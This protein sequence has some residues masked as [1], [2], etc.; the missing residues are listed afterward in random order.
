MTQAPRLHFADRRRAYA[1]TIADYLR[2]C[3][4]LCLLT[5]MPGNAG[6]QLIWAGT[7]RLL[8]TH[9]IEVVHY[10]VEAVATTGRAIDRTLLVPGS[11]AWVALWHEWLPALVSAASTRFG[12]VVVLP[13]QFDPR[14]PVV[15][16]ALRQPNVVVF[17]REVPSYRA[18]KVFGRAV[19]AMD[20]ALYAWD[21]E[22]APPGGPTARALAGPRLV[23]L[24]TDAGSLLAGWGLRPNPALADDISA[25]TTDLSEFLGA[26]SASA[27]V[28]TDRLH[29]AVAAI[30][31]GR[32]VDYVDPVD[33]KISTYL[34]F[35]FGSDLGDRA[36]RRD[37]TWLVEQGCAVP[38]GSRT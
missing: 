14:V 31:S 13:S 17:A 35:T 18:V 26:V 34:D 27:R 5:G 19:L 1:A 33:D 30:M 20:L 29:V 8:E 11:G 7:R 12:R 36:V 25:T 4:G 10:P 16:E 23:A 32:P 21:F 6:D 37:A 3:P 28:V 15:A 38:I 22:L 9:G 24:R 2:G